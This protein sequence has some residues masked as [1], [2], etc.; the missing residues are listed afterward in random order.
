MK[1]RAKILLGGKTATGIHIPD[2]AVAALGQSRKPAVRVTIR[3]YTYRTSISS[4]GKKF[5]LPVSAEARAGAGVEAGDEVDVER[6]QEARLGASRP[7]HSDG[8]TGRQG[9]RR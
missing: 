4:M 1:L 7:R 9:M 8:N 6:R 5:M 3:G 2:E